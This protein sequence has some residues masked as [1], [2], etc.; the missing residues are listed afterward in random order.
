MRK[1]LASLIIFGGI[2]FVLTGCTT[3][4]SY[5][6]DVETGDKIEVKLNTT[7]GYDITSDLP[8]SIINDGKTLSQGTFI[9]LDNYNQYISVVSSDSGAKIIDSATK[10]GLQYTFYSYNNSEW[11]YVIKVVGSNTG[12][13]LGNPISEESARTCF[14]RLTISKK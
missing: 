10:N 3:S 12:L 6:F 9:T 4:K 13:L 7:D 1:F 2:L 5:T 11:N 14:D 8:F